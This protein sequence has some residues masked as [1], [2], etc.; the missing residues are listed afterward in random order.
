[1]E[2]T[3]VRINQNIRHGDF[4]NQFVVATETRSSAV[5]ERLRVTVSVVEILKCS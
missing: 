3:L 2:Q 1:L 5:A 4:A